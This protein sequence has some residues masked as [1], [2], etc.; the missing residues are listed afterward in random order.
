MMDYGAV[1]NYLMA[2]LYVWDGAYPVTS[3]GSTL[4]GVIVSL[5]HSSY[6]SVAVGV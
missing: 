4:G 1:S 6:V 5:S 2:G 3:A